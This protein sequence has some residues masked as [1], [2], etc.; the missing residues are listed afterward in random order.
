MLSYFLLNVNII[1]ITAFSQVLRGAEDP[2]GMRK[3]IESG[4]AESALNLKNIWDFE[5]RNKENKY[6]NL[7]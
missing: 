4:E 7:K 3:E 2:T 5:V 6:S 1:I